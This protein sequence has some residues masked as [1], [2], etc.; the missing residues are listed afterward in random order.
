MLDFGGENLRTTGHFPDVTKF[1]HFPALSQISSASWAQKDGAKREEEDYICR[2][3][4]LNGINESENIWV[5][6]RAI[7]GGDLELSLF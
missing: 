5:G 1:I 2:N 6:K 3:I 7:I 4:H